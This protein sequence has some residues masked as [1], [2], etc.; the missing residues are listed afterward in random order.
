M[1]KCINPLSFFDR[2]TGDFHEN[3]P[4]GHC[5]PCQ[6]R[7]RAEWDLRLTVE[8]MFSVS[9]AFVTFTYDDENIGSAHDYRNFQLLHKRMRNDGIRFSF[10][11]TSEFGTKKGRPH[12]H[13]LIFFKSP[14]DHLLLYNYH[15]KGIM[16]V[17]TC[18]P[19]SIH[20]VTK[21]HVHPKYRVGESLEKH[22]FTRMS[23][24]LGS[25]LV[26]YA[27]SF[28]PVYKLNGNLYPVSRYYRKRYSIDVSDFHHT[29]LWDDYHQKFPFVT[30]DYF[31]EYLN[32]LRQLNI[33]NQ[34]QSYGIF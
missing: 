23:K 20:Y 3:I 4:C 2:N 28:K 14:F 34:Q 33:L 31:L 16:D 25:Q 5:Y 7:K 21:W 27:D 22:G 26:L 17:G 1:Y 30:Y 11:H 19:A 13:E 29:S 12:N 24:G 6:M 15:H 32:Q 9:S 8:A 18:S 10:Y